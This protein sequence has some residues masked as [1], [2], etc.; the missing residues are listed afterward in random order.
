MSDVGDQGVQADSAATHRLTDRYRGCLL[1]LACGDALGGPLEFR[2]RGEIAHD[3]PDGLREFIGGGW[4]SLAPGEITD[5]T[6]MTLALARALA[7]TSFRMERVVE[8]FLA[9]YRSEPKDIGRTTRQALS[10][11]AAGEWWE[12][13]GEAAV[14]ANPGG[15]AGN[16]SVMRCAPVA[17]RYRRDPEALQRVSLDTARIT[18]ADPRSAWG[19][20]AV[21]QAI[22]HLLAGRPLDAAISAAVDG[23]PE[24]SVRAAVLDASARDDAPRRAGGFVLDTIAAASWC[25]RQTS[26]FEDAVVA[27]VGLGDDT[28]TTGAVTGALAGAAYGLVQIPGRWV[29][30]VQFRDELRALADRLLDL[31]ERETR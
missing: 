8:E 28:D 3:Y 21:N 25:L 27:A 15:A 13:A 22:V 16:G 18:H 10:R 4:L 23:I 1:G 24:A 11:L 19:A 9:W 26:S 7:D 30:R 6:Q 17:L 20:V 12:T 5:D 31:A 2:S 29:D 14:A